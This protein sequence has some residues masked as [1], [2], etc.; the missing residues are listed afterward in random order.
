MFARAI[1]MSDYYCFSDGKG[2]WALLRY[3]SL[4]GAAGSMVVIS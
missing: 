2:D 1:Q 3:A 4:V